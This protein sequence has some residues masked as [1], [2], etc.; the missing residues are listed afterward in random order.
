L[1]DLE[2]VPISRTRILAGVNSLFA[3][4]F[5]LGHLSSNPASELA[6]P[7]YEN[8]LAER[9]MT[10]ED[11]QRMLTAEIHAR[12]RILHILLH[13]AGLRVSEAC[14]LQWRNLHERGKSGQ[15]TVFGKNGRTRA[16]TLPA[17][18]WAELA[19]WREAA[20][21]E[22]LV[23]PSRSGRSLDRGRVRMILRRA[24]RRVGIGERV[25]PH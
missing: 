10:V 17:D 23:F 4:G 25:S 8:R 5:R 20:R 18:L 15:F 7:A 11:V 1:V 24:A 9:I 2:L 16:I 21:S 19:R 13:V 3:F 12:N 14:R 6:L 22:D